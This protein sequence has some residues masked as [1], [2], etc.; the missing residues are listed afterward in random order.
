MYHPSTEVCGPAVVAAHAVVEL[1]VLVVA[2]VWVAPHEQRRGR[3]AESVHID[4]VGVTL[5]PFLAPAGAEHYVG[6]NYAGAKLTIQLAKVNA[7]SCALGKEG[8]SL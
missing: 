4:L 8:I 6:P 1:G 7:L 3:G 2:L 5:L